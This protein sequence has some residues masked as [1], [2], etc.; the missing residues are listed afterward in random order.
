MTAPEN[1]IANDRAAA[2]ARVDPPHAQGLELAPFQ[3]HPLLRG[4]HFQTLASVYFPGP[5]LEYRARQHLIP[6]ADGDGIVLHEDDPVAGVPESSPADEPIALLVHG[7]GGSHLSGYM[8]RTAAKLAV[9]GTRVFRMDLRGYGCGFAHARHPVHAGRS[10]DVAAALAWL[11]ARFPQQGVTAVGY[12]MG[13]NLVLRM[14]GKFA[15]APPANLRS[16]MAVSPPID[17]EHC[18]RGIRVGLNRLYDRHFVKE[19]LLHLSRRRKEVPGVLDRIVV[20]PPRRLF[21]F[22]NEFTAPVCGF[23]DVYDYY[24]QASSAPLLAQIVVPTLIVSAADDPIVCAAMFENASYSPSTRVVITPSGG[25]L[26]FIGIRGIDPD[27]RWLDWRTLE[28]VQHNSASPQVPSQSRPLSDS[29]PA[30][31]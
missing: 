25:H 14:A 15:A 16:V 19:L 11:A 28:W 4:G 26:G 8:Q 6:L 24:A 10:D 17:L 27:R 5:K 20:P 3:P 21:E 7:L 13:A 31:G 18:S 2:Q 9:R 30:G 22:D 1:S 23:S 29:L 12:S